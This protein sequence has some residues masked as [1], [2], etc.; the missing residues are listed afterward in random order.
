MEAVHA[1]HPLRGMTYSQARRLAVAAGVIVIGLVAVVMYARRVETVEVVAVLLFLP[2]FGALLRWNEVGGLLGGLIAGGVYLVLRLPAIH[3]VGS[4]RLTGLV[5][6][7]LL[8][9]VAFGVVGGWAN[10][11]LKE[12]LTKLDL[13]D[14]IDDATGLFNARFFVL[15]TDL[16]MA[17]AERYRTFFGL[18][19]VDLPLVWFDGQGRRRGD[20]A[21]RELA[22]SLDDSVRT[23]DRCVHVVAGESHRFAVLLPETGPE[24]VRVFGDRLAARM[25]AFLVER[26]VAPT[27]SVVENTSLAY[28]EDEA[29]IHRLRDAF[30]AI[31][32]AE[33]PLVQD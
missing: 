21:L 8:A 18:T 13:Y 15:D 29:E 17:R 25:A 27:G 19:V 14:Q 6:S 33:H 32:H 28:P 1:A 24:G 12:S 23:V 20:R 2:V 3:A 11:Q 4:G 10:R 16:E 26:G 30:R 31:S 7:R 22:R 5:G 9:L